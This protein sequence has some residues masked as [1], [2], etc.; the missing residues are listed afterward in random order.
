[1]KT[2]Q[3]ILA[4]FS[5]FIITTILT[6]PEPDQ[7]K[8]EVELKMGAFLQKERKRNNY[9]E[10]ISYQNNQWS[11]TGSSMGS[12][13]AKSMLNMLVDN[14][15]SSTNYILF[16]T[17]NITFEGQTS[18]VGIGILGNIFLFD[19]IDEAMNHSKYLF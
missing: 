5:L 13:L 1:M 16:S 10:N 17:T 6:N 15:V 18:T 2:K 4:V 19:N 11:D 3:Y 8:E 14:M 9:N 7:H 12:M